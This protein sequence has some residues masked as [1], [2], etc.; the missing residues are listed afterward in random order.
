MTMDI[1]LTP[2]LEDFVAEQIATGRYAN[3]DE[4]VHAALELLEKKQAHGA[5]LHDLRTALDE[6]D[7]NPD[8]PFDGEE[9]IVRGK[10]R[11]ARAEATEYDI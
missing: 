9:I 4:V 6:G 2:E 8:A 3:A 10:E 5:K 11:R 1:D 7:N